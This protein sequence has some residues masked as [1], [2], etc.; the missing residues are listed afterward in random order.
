VNE[1]WAT[2]HHYSDSQPTLERLHFLKDS[3]VELRCA[4][5]GWG[6][7]VEPGAPLRVDL[8]EY[9]ELQAVRLTKDDALGRLEGCTIIRV[10]PLVAAGLTSD[11]VGYVLVDSSNYRCALWCTSDE[12]RVGTEWDREALGRWSVKEVAE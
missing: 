9:G 5:S 2:Y 1:V 12:L 4:R 10:N 8:V 6:I 3:W 11:P 7:S